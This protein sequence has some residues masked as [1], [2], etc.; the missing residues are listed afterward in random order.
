MKK[1]IGIIG[2]GNMGAAIIG[3]IYKK[4][5]VG[6]CEQDKKKS[7]NLK[8]KFK[9]VVG[10]LETIVNKSQV[11]I[12]AVKP[13]NFEDVLSQV[14]KYISK[15]K[16]VISIAAGITTKYIEKLLDVK[17]KI[18]VIRSMP[19]LPAQVNCGITAICKGRYAT[20]NDLIAASDVFKNIGKTIILDEKYIDSVT[21]VSGSG[22]AYVFLFVECMMKAAQS[23]GFKKDK[24]RLLVM[25][26]LK[27]SLKL[28]EERNVE[29][30]VLRSQVT[31]K[32]GT[33]QAAMDVFLKNGIDTVF[34][35]AIKRAQKRAKELAK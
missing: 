3:S 33:T 5:N 34:E 32:G 26:T 7:G 8:R 19:N 16:L 22:P 31:S 24:A 21:A 2:G 20:R 1:T 14:K 11:I 17:K 6:V 12:L 29:P 9:I 27:G 4:Y 25:E 30:K 35:K 15:D 23:L 10:D 28:L 13:Q 18:K